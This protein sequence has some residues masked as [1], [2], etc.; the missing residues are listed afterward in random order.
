V[1]IQ[2]TKED[3]RKKS[4]NVL[5][6]ENQFCSYGHQVEEES[7]AQAQEPHGRITRSKAKVLGKEHQMLSLFVIT[8][9]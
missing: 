5:F 9:V 1:H 8:L 7:E 4:Q 2:I 3:T 6:S